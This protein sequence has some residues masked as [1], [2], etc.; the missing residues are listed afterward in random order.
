MKPAAQIR[1]DGPT[2][3]ENDDNLDLAPE[4][5]GADSRDGTG[6]IGADASDTAADS[7]RHDIVQVLEE[8]RLH[9]GGGDDSVALDNGTLRTGYRHMLQDRDDASE[10]GSA[11]GLPRRAGSPI[12]SLLSVP[13]DSP[14]VQV[15]PL[16]LTCCDSRM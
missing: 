11:D 2:G 1:D 16:E 13:D 10:S 6:D 14:S 5:Q 9:S 4:G 15:R 12:D 3:M 7:D 8:E